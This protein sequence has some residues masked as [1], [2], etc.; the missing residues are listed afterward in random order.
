MGNWMTVNM[1]GTMTE[2]DAAA[3]REYLGYSFQVRGDPAMG[4]FGPL[5]FNREQPSICGLN[6]WPA[7]EVA[8][9]GN[10]AERGFDVADVAEELRTLVTVAGSMMLTV[11][12]GGDNESLDCVATI[13]VSE[14]LVSAG[15]PEV[16]RLEEIGDTQALANMLRALSGGY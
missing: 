8:R 14:G 7:P 13:R 3:L 10:L 5:S 2:Q 4:R 12:C 11:H 6:D 16:E 9:A 1:S 15:K